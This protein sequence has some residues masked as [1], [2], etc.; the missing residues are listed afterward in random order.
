MFT[1]RPS[2][3][4]SFSSG[5]SPYSSGEL[6]TKQCDVVWVDLDGLPHRLG[7]ELPLVIG[8]HEAVGCLDRIAFL[9]GLEDGGNTPLRLPIR[10]GCASHDLRGHEA[11]A[12]SHD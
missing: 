1:K 5:M 7:E 9:Q 10:H 4:S 11:Q 6:L 2:S 8:A 3:F 12:H